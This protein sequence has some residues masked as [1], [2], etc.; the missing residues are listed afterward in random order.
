[1]F[2]AAGRELLASGR[3]A[4]PGRSAPGVIRPG[5]T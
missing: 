2:D 4:N 1:M 5:E 3:P